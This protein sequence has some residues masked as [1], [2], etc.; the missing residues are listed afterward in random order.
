MLRICENKRGDK[1]FEAIIIAVA[2]GLTL[3]CGKSILARARMFI[4]KYRIKKALV[5]RINLDI[6][7]KCAS[8][9]YYNALDKFL[10]E[11]DFASKIVKYSFEPSSMP[12]STLK[13]YI[14]YLAEK[15]I[16]NN[17]SFLYEK[18]RIYFDLNTF[19]KIIFDI[20]ND[21]SKDETAR[22]VISQFKETLG[23]TIA[24]LQESVKSLEKNIDK[25]TTP[26]SQDAKPVDFDDE[27]KIRIYKSSM[28]AQY[29]FEDAYISR[30]IY[31]GND[32]AQSSV[33]CLL[34]D[35]RIILLGNPGCGKTYESINVLRE[36]CANETL[37]HYIP[38]Y[39]R[40]REYGT[41]YKSLCEYI[42]KQIEPYWGKITDEKVTEELKANR[43]ALILDGVDEIINS[44]YRIKF[45]SEINS[46]L[47]LANSLFFV[48]SR[49]NPYH[50]NINGA[51]EYRINDL[52][53]EQIR[54]E[55]QDSGVYLSISRQYYELF[56]NPLFLN[57]GKR[58]LVNSGRSKL[59]N[60][61]QL[62]NAYLEEVCYKRD[63]TKL[64]ATD[65]QKNYHNILMSVGHLAFEKFEK[66]FLSIAEFDEFFGVE[67]K[68]YTVDNIC[69]VFRIDIF[70]VSNN[71]SFSH[72][73]FK[74]F[75]AAYY[76]TKK[77]IVTQ[78]SELYLSL[79]SDAN[80]QEVMVFAA[81][82]IDDIDEQNAFLDMILKIN[83][84]TY[85]ACV[86][87]KND[88]SYLC[89][90]LS[91]EEYSKKYLDVLYQSYIGILESYFPNIKEK[92]EPFSSRD[93]ET[94]KEKK[95][96]LI[97]SL[98]PDRKHLHYWFDWKDQRED[99]VQLISENDMPE[100]YK[101]LEMRA[102]MEERRI[103]T[104]GVNL[105][106]SNL[107]G[108]SARKVVL[109]LI[110]NN[111]EDITKNFRLYD[112]D[113]ILY[114]KLRSKTRRIKELTDKSIEEI[115]KWCLRLIEEAQERCMNLRGYNYNGVELF[116]VLWIARALVDRGKWEKDL[117]LPQ[118]DQPFK[119]GW[120]WETYS[121]ART[122][123]RLQIFFL[124]RQQSFEEMVE[125]NFPRMKEYFARSK[126]SPYRY[127]I[128]LK[129]NEGE[130]F[131]SHPSITYYYLSIRDGE[132]NMPEVIICDDLPGHNDDVFN[133]ISE[134][135]YS[136]GKEGDHM[137]ISTTGFDMTLTSRTSGEPMPLTSVVYDDFK[138]AFKELFE[139]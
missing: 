3:E 138:S 99:S 43:F 111:L 92:F 48:T 83:L 133:L 70:R 120:I 51:K 105:D 101:D 125:Y 79:M 2:E 84:K 21:Y 41:V 87:Y 42:E 22:L 128:H 8:T 17:P 33:T 63:K 24:P 45:F 97:G 123:E 49:T 34:R 104:H 106:L 14:K 26:T 11:E 59:Y 109:D 20:I 91:Y 114:E 66:P 10:S 68:E 86:K 82:L 1:M 36:F 7:S 19:S 108:D 30:N 74:E 16:Q 55:L 71:I 112:S 102:I 69:D 37:A 72:K 29:I 50:G 124:W 77:Y 25:L 85:I 116:D 137:T 73:Q 46:L 100:S 78:N 32:D 64:L 65:I 13:E 93:L 90:E 9:A 67:G 62:F 98:S 95:V 18:S 80:W 39:M 5:K 6:L 113:Y 134:S 96:C 107:M 81:G 54:K 27:S 139:K 131:S 115:A 15:F 44:E 89:Q 122:I 103:I 61:S 57:I 135:F 129:F 94:L 130:G 4:K 88:L 28:I 126:D 127:R 76:L 52:T 110:E 23:E 12:I 35:K 47:S 31:T 132:S 38:V 60:K 53:Q 58:V 121:T 118:G 40:L 117:E 136:N 75:L 56:A 119:Y